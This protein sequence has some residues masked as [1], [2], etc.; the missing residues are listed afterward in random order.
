MY[1]YLFF[2]IAFSFSPSFFSS[3]YPYKEGE[4]LIKLV[5]EL[6][7]F[8][9]TSSYFYAS[10]MNRTNNLCLENHIE[11]GVSGLLEID[12]PIEITKKIIK[13]YVVNKHM[14]TTAFSQLFITKFENKSKVQNIS[15]IGYMSMLRNLSYKNYSFLCKD[16]QDYMYIL[17]DFNNNKKIK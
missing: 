11:N 1:K 5:K 8:C 7:I 13:N 9:N 16:N 12:S 3:S 4:K 15:K 6:L 10:F 14:E 17:I 2:F